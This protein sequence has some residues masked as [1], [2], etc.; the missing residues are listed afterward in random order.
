MIKIEEAMCAAVKE[1][2][3][4]KS[5]NNKLN[6]EKPRTIIEVDTELE[7][8]KDE[9]FELLKENLELEIDTN[10]ELQTSI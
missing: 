10:M 2:R 1:H 3:Y 5:G 9:L 6:V 4:L 8:A 7:K